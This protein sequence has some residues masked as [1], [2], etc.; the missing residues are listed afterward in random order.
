MM[1]P[2]VGNEVKLYTYLNV[3]EDANMTFGFFDK[4]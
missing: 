2:S 4:R 1:L 3:R